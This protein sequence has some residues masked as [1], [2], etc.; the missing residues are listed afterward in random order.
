M[1]TSFHPFTRLPITLQSDILASALPQEPVLIS[2]FWNRNTPTSRECSLFLPKNSSYR[3][4]QN[5]AV[6]ND[7]LSPLVPIYLTQTE[8]SSQSQ[9]SP[10][11][12]LKTETIFLRPSI[13]ILYLPYQFFQKSVSTCLYIP[14]FMSRETTQKIRRLAIS[15]MDLYF[16]FWRELHPNRVPESPLRQVVF[17]LRNLE[18]LYVIGGDERARLSLPWHP[19]PRTKREEQ[20]DRI[21]N[22]VVGKWTGEE[23]VELVGLGEGTFQ[24][25]GSRFG[26]IRGEVERHLRQPL[27][28]FMAI[29]KMWRSLVENVEK[30]K[31]MSEWKVPRV[32][33]C[34]VS[35]IGE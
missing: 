2:A 35:C 4:L 13:D 19:Q 1:A 22:V 6:L 3:T 20:G 10:L 21:S 8:P 24:M 29:E 15:L 31:E 28:T 9:E 30:K 27:G 12:A 16:I 7:P 32:V 14:D 5:I 23:D 18:V 17:G 25:Q 33:G 34:E 26:G 11:P